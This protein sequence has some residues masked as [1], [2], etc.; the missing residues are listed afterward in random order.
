MDSESGTEFLFSNVGA[1]FLIGAAVG[2]F[3]KKAIK[4]VLFFGGLAIAALFFMENQGI[5]AV[6]DEGLK[7]TASIVAEK[8]KELGSLLTSRL[9]NITGKG[10]SAA[11]GFV[12]GFKMG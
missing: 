9:D 1:P 4:L 7:D 3:A 5:T 8:M 10:V 6:D 11:V 2:F 12:A